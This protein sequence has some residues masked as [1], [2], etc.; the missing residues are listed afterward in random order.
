MI[1]QVYTFTGADS[2]YPSTVI[3]AFCAE[4]SRDLV[5]RLANGHIYSP[6]ENVGVVLVLDM[7]H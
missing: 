1:S 4:E 6:E 3:E 2:Q 5:T 7:K